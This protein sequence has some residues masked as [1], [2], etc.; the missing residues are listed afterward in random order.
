MA[1]STQQQLLVEQRL[2]NDK[3]SM[4]AAYALWFFVGMFG[5]H[6]FYLGRSGSAIAQLVLTIVGFLTLVIGI[7]AVLLLAVAIWVLVD[8]FL[9]PG[10]IEADTSNKR[11]RLMTEVGLTT[12]A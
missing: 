3:K 9:I 8:A 2:Q 1:L 4:G 10:M 5:G 12:A 7:G 6:R 11:T